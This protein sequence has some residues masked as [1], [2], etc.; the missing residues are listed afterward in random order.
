M[1]LRAL[2]ARLDEP[3]GRREYL[4]VGLVL[5]LTKYIVDASVI[6][7]AAGMVWTPFDYLV[8]LVSMTGPKVVQFSPG[9]GLA[10]LLFALP[11]V[12]IGV[13]MSVRRAE[14][15]GVSPWWVVAFF[16]PGLNYLLMAVL[17]MLPTAGRP[18]STREPGSAGRSPRMAVLWGG[19]AGALTGV[20]LTAVGLL[21]QTYGITLFVGTPFL[22]GAVAAYVCGRTGGLETYRGILA[23]FLSLAGGGLA[24]T[25][26]AIEGMVCIL[27][28]IPIAS[29]IVVLGALVGHSVARRHSTTFAGLAMVFALVPAGALIEH[30][31]SPVPARVVTTTIE[32]D[33]SPEQ[34][35]P[36]VV[37]FEEISTPPAWYFRTGLAYPLRA[38]IV[39]S[40]VGAMRYC[41][42]TTGA[43]VEPITAW[44]APHRLAFDVASHPPP[45]QEWSP[46]SKVYAPHLDGY[47]RTERGEFRLTALPGGRTR[48]EGHS[49]YTL[50]MS[51][52]PYWNMIADRILHDIHERVLAH[53]K[54]TAERHVVR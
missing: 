16:L 2:F 22:M 28:A 23:A 35:W 25:L 50:R 33:A 36:F 26:V 51:P 11:F 18:A 47:F 4:I 45:L 19:M 54:V 31:T 41:E 46:Y 29:P 40:G 13:T 15:A 42:F 5:S 6:Y 21:G 53:I 52:A 8:P 30:A 44:D 34:V 37:S 32:V 39:G 9:L 27:M 12:W 38:R 20:V 49:W 10:L 3:V 48:L 17:A 24:L 1:M 43:F 14:D 7:F